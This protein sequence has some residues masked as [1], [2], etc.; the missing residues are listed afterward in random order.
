M[1]N[2]N[3]LKVKFKDILIGDWFTNIIEGSKYHHYYMKTDSGYK[4]YGDG[5]IEPINCVVMEGPRTGD[6][7]GFDGNYEVYVGKI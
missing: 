7:E 6:L 1:N 5:Y 4:V 3:C 2:Y